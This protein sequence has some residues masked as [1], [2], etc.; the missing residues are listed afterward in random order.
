MK[1]MNHTIWCCDI[2]DYILMEVFFQSTKIYL[3]F[4]IKKYMTNYNFDGN[5]IFIA[6]KRRTI[7]ERS[8]FNLETIMS[9]AMHI[10]KF[11]DLCGNLM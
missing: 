5:N 4:K 6:I 9:Q 8:Q 10:C 2:V 1:R 7:L 11:N 3:Q